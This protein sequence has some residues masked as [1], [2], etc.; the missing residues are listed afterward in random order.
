MSVVGGCGNE[1][2]AGVM[3]RKPDIHLVVMSVLDLP[4]ARLK[5][6]CR[7]LAMARFIIV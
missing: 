2:K 5:A 3:A 4:L 7:R 1:V 6:R